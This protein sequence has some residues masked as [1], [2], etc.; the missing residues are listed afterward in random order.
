MVQLRE[1]LTAGERGR[2]IRALQVT[3]A[4]NLAS[5]VEDL[6][7]SRMADND[8]FVRVEA[9]RA[10]GDCVSSAARVALREALMD[11]SVAVQQAAEES[12]QRVATQPPP[13][14]TNTPFMPPI[15]QDWLR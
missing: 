8:H 4:M 10:L 7:V 5:S 3:V 12:L 13:L 6:L 15:I 9:A 14:S 1:E 11:S 2:L